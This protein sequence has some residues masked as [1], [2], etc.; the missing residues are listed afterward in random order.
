MSTTATPGQTV[1]MSFVIDSQGNEGTVQTSVVF[2]ASILSNP[3]V[4]LGSGA[5]GGSGVGTNTSQVAQ[6]RIGVQVFG[7][8]SYA[9][10]TKQMF[11]ITFNVAPGAAAGTYPVTFSGTPSPQSVSAATGGAILTDVTYQS[12]NI[13]IGTTAA[14]VEVSGRV[15]TA[16]GR[17]LRNATVVITDAAGRR[18]T[19][20]TGTF[21]SYRFNDV[22]AG[23]SYV[24]A[25]T[26][27]RYR[28]A[29]RV[30]NIADSLND[31]D[32]MAIE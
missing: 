1:T 24:M 14:G 4:A 30:V 9:A 21:G 26:S 29:S 5:P 7:P 10:G 17:G 20:T 31:V 28:F 13:V 3:Q 2:P 11:T 19:T 12:G 32:F 15:T 16:D 22:E 6:G 27:N 25:V 8:N 23:R 18:R